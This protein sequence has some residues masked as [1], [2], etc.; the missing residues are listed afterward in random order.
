MLN[1]D[2]TLS[3]N[4][5]F[6]FF[7]YCEITFNYI[8]YIIITNRSIFWYSYRKDSLEQKND[9]NLTKCE[10]SKL[11]KVLNKFS[12]IFVNRSQKK[13]FF[14]GACLKLINPIQN[15]NHWLSGKH[16]RRTTTALIQ[17]KKNLPVCNVQ[18]D[19]AITTLQVTIEN[20]KLHNSWIE[21]KKYNKIK[22]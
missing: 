21:K 22:L 20:L 5:L 14:K 18:M 1:A 13:C 2:N 19:K 12:E 17:R 15:I 11:K 16:E 9:L 7:L 8:L 4:L 6:S 10:K 3:Q